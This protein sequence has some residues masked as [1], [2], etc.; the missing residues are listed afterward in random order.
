VYYVDEVERLEAAVS[1]QLPKNAQQAKAIANQL[2]SNQQLTQALA[3]A[4]RAPIQAHLYGIDRLPAA[5]IN[6]G[7]GVIYGSTD[8]AKLLSV[9]KS[10]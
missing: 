7:E 2:Q 5:V 10:K 8:V 1:R 6:G 4:Y 9:A 3:K